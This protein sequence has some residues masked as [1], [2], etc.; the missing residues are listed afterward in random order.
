[1]IKFFRKT[2]LDLMTKNKTGSYLKYAIGEVILVVVGILIALQINDWN[3]QRKDSLKEQKILNQLKSEYESNLAQLDEKILMRNEGLGACQRLLQLIDNPSKLIEHEFY[4]DL[5]KLVRDPTFDPI[6]NDII[7]S[8]NLRIIKNDSLIRALSNW[9]MEVFQVQELEIEYTRFRSN[10]LVP[11]YTKLGLA[12]NMNNELW[13]NG[14]TPVEALDKSK[15]VTYFLKQSKKPLN[16]LE[17]LN[18]TELE[19][20]IST[21]FSYYQVANIQSYTLRDRIISILEMINKSIDDE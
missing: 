3:E 2:R 4:D 13:K 12:R 18:D 7:E 19:G 15:S 10:F 8:E 9:S 5:W 21:A 11:N 1:M 14:Y 16:L 20:N 6:K 17:V